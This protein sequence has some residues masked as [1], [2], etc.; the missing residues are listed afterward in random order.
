MTELSFVRTDRPDAPPLYEQLYKAI[1]GQIASGHI[2]PGEKLPGK[3]SLAS[4]LGLSVNTVDSAYQLLSAEGWL[5]ARPRSGF[6]VMKYDRPLREPAP[7]A[8]PELEPDPAPSFQ[9]DLSTS[10]V[11][12]GFFPFH[13][14]GRI[15]RDLLYNQPDLLAHGHPQGDPELRCAIADYLLAYRGV[16]C[17]PD[18]LVVGAG[19]EYLLGLLG[20]LLGGAAAALEDPGYKRI[21]T[22]LQNSGLRC[23]PVPVDNLGL[24]PEALAQSS[25]S[26][27]YVTPSHQFPTGAVMPVGRRAA[28][29][30]WAEQQPGR[31][32]IED[33]YDSEFRFRIRPLPSL[34]GMAGR[35]GQVIYLSTFSRS[36]A[37]SIRIAYMVLPRWLLKKFKHTFRGYSSTV[38]RFEQQTLRIFLQEGHYLRHLARSRSQYQNRMQRLI[39]SLEQAF[40]PGTLEFSGQHTG[41]HLLLR[42]PN[43]PGEQALVKAA[44]AAGVQLSGLSEYSTG[45]APIPDNMLVIGYGGIPADQID[46][47]ALTLHQAW[48]ALA[49]VSPVPLPPTSK[50]ALS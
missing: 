1:S 32:I 45:P 40:G 21:W 8:H 48:S 18:Q 35:D 20:R 9:Y 22:I 15:Q 49:P 42:L 27:V 33:D 12:T 26:V 19:V 34:Q 4:A 37:P 41:I 30:R 44:R 29:L 23:I 47:L 31:V 14:W 11:D 25:A 10:S 13:Q 6:F 50:S 3:R 28:L 17:T 46:E 7:A 16:D 38:S 39:S 43:G 5:E 36:L 24:D 2:L